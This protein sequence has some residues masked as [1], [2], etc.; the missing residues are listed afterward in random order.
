MQMGIIGALHGKI[1]TIINFG[2]AMFITSGIE[3]SDE[4][5]EKA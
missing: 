5:G 3:K 1:T 4:K 2:D